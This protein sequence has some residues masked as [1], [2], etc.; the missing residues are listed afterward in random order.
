M[1]FCDSGADERVIWRTRDGRDERD[2]RDEFT[3][4]RALRNVSTARERRAV[5]RVLFDF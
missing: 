5:A 1:G 2:A 3:S 4:S